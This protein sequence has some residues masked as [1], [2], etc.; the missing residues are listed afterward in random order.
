M[1]NF[2]AQKYS[3]NAEVARDDGELAGYI[4]RETGLNCVEVFSEGA[5]SENTSVPQHLTAL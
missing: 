2:I 3:K 1:Y 5:P 4:I